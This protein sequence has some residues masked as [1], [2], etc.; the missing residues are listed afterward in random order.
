MIRDIAAANKNLMTFKEIR[1]DI[2]CIAA[3]HTH[4]MFPHFEFL[5]LGDAL[6]GNVSGY[7][8]QFLPETY[9]LMHQDLSVCLD[10]GWK[11]QTKFESYISYYDT[12]DDNI[13]II[14]H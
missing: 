14:W 12:L 6:T 7:Q 10:G 2:K 11:R 4:F 5:Q 8:G 3:L 13:K 9:F 1:A